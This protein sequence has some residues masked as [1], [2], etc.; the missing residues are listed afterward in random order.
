MLRLCGRLPLSRKVTVLEELIGNK[1]KDLCVEMGKA[2]D[3]GAFDRGRKCSPNR[4]Q[5][6]CCRIFLGFVLVFRVFCLFLVWFFVC[7]LA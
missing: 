3:T 2:Q 5:C 7:L 4:A 1:R 6:E